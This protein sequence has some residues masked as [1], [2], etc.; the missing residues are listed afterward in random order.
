MLSASAIVGPM[1]SPQ[2]TL[3]V[4]LLPGSVV[5]MSQLTPLISAADATVQATTI[6]GLYTLQGPAANLDQLAEELAS[7]PAVQY[8][9]PAG[10]VQ[11]LTAPNDP[12]YVNGDDWQLNGT[13]GINAP[14]AWNVTTGSDEVIVADT[15]TGMAYNVPDLVDNVWINQAEIPATVLPNL[16]DVYND[17]AITFTDLNNP[18][19]QGPGKITATNGV[20]NGS[21]VLAPTSSGGWADGSTQDGDTA[22]PDDLIGWNFSAITTSTPNGT[23]NPIDQNGHG[24]FTAG[25]IAEVG[26]NG[27]A[28]TGVDWNV[29]LMPVQFLDVLGQRLRLC[30]RRGDRV[31]GQPRRQGHQ[32]QLGRDRDGSHHRR[33]DPV[34]R[35]ERGDHRLRRRQQRDRR[36]Q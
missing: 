11:D 31:R 30:G 33:R 2:E 15:D 28:G 5:T 17:G 20:V 6:S 12:D 23:N 32:R 34:R 3:D 35:P 29:Q 13:W 26:N 22:N 21:S 7:N 36:R 25:E 24:T 9:A 4:Q 27:I 19:N 18:V 10:T 8:A 14:A 1:P 16:T